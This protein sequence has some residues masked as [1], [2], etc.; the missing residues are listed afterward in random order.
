MDFALM[1]AVLS[2]SWK[3]LEFTSKL[4]SSLFYMFYKERGTLI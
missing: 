2:L 3:I 1:G 4:S